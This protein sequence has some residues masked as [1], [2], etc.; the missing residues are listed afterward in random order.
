[1]RKLTLVGLLVAVRLVGCSACAT[2]DDAASRYDYVL[3]ELKRSGPGSGMIAGEWYLVSLSMAGLAAQNLGRHEDLAW[4][5]RRAFD[6]EVRAFDT[7]EWRSD[8]LATLDSDQGH[9]GFLGHA[10]LLLALECSDAN[11]SLR[12]RVLGALERRYA[13]SPSRLI[14]TYPGRTWIPD[15]AVTLA[16][17]AL[18]A[19]CDRRDVPTREWLAR[20]PTDR[21]TGLLRFTPESATPRASGA[22]WSTLYLHFV[23]SAFARAQFEEAERV[24]LFDAVPGLAAWREYPR[25][26]EGQGDVDSGPLVFGLSPSGTGFALAGATL[27][28]SKARAGM[29]RTAEAAGLSVPWGGLHYLLAPLV[30]DA[31]VLAAKTL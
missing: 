1:M 15:N 24:F 25:G 10:G 30:G 21:A 16:A 27:Y 6:P 5:T 17:V 29:L 18:G 28:R 22:G 9:A 13:E 7:Q 31:A 2:R 3:A 8:A 12:H 4:L 11:A 14:E 26:R 23:D 20:W 19:R